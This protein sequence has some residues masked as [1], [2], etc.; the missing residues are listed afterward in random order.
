MIIIFVFLGCL[1]LF[2]VFVLPIFQRG[3]DYFKE[4]IDNESLKSDESKF[5][6]LRNQENT[7]AKK[8]YIQGKNFYKLQSN[9]KL[10]EIYDNKESLH[11]LELLALEE[12]MVK[13]KLLKSSLTQVKI[14]QIENHFINK[15]EKPYQKT[16]GF[17]FNEFASILSFI[18]INY[19]S[20]QIDKIFRM[21]NELS[22]SVFY[23]SFREIDM[24]PISIN[25]IKKSEN[26]EYNLIWEDLKKTINDLPAKL[27]DNK[28]EYKT[29]KC[30]PLIRELIMDTSKK[31]IKIGK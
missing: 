14:E 22:E 23:S 28:Y 8:K 17:E 2:I 24:L 13:N 6:R 3:S 18:I 16:S 15:K 7:N 19:D 5:E 31:I 30:K 20:S 9:E 21:S 25:L 4:L 10:N 29:D 26:L 27:K 12:I 11:P 1:I